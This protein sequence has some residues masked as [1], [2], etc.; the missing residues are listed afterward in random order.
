MIGLDGNCFLLK[1]WGVSQSLII[2]AP[3]TGHV[4]N[5]EHANSY[6]ESG[7][8]KIYVMPM[9]QDIYE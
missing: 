7:H 6:E 2:T 5:E 8:G 1:G 3:Y 4:A 9:E